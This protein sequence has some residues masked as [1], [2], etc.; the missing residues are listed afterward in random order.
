MDVEDT[1]FAFE[2]YSD[3]VELCYSSIMLTTCGSWT[4]RESTDTSKENCKC[5]E[6]KIQAKKQQRTIHIYMLLMTHKL[7][8]QILFCP[9]QH[10]S[11]S[12]RKNR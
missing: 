12:T 10:P 6:S 9:Q 8:P 7:S 5:Y 3:T 4:Y 2:V 11:Q 1:N